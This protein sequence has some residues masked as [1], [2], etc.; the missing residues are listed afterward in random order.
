[1][2]DREHSP[3]ELC[4]DSVL[5]PVRAGMVPAPEPYRW[6]SYVATVGR[7]APAFLT[8]AWVPSP[9]GQ[10]QRSAQARYAMFVQEG[11]G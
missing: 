1:V 10:S 5:N 4:R 8:T 9:F 3:L 11:I 7:Q 2:V 6:N